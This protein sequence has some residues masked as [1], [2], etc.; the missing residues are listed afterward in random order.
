MPTTSGNA[1]TLLL[2]VLFSSVRNQ[3]HKLFL[4]SKSTTLALYLQS[5]QLHTS[6]ANSQQTHIPQI[7][8]GAT[9][10]PGTS[11]VDSFAYFLQK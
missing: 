6:L 8:L 11:P 1:L 5:R 2:T 4:F 10:S 3:Y 9:T 7:L